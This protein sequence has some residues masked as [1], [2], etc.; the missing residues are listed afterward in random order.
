MKNKVF[1]YKK[2]VVKRS[3]MY[4]YINYLITV[5]GI[6]SGKL[7]TIGTIVQRTHST[8][9]DTGEVLEVLKSAGLVP[10]GCGVFD[11]AKIPWYTYAEKNNIDIVDICNI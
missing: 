3:K 6:K 8:P 11:D 1:Y 2:D 9:G 5:Y 4:G 10:K 7:Y